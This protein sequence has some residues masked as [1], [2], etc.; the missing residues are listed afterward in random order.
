MPAVKAIGSH[1]KGIKCKGNNFDGSRKE[2]LGFYNEPSIS[3][4]RHQYSAVI[5]GLNEYSFLHR[6]RDGLNNFSVGY[7]LTLKRYLHQH[8]MKGGQRKY[9]SI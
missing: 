1:D 2:I 4:T 6:H 3:I 5:N 9:S 8:K 7:G